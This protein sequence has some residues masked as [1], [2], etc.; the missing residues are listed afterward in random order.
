MFIYHGFQKPSCLFFS[1][2]LFP[3]FHFCIGLF[4]VHLEHPPS[5]LLCC[6]YINHISGFRCR[7]LLSMV[8]FLLY[9]GLSV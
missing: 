2:F 4:C 7:F 9:F 3:F 6:F 8:S 1:P 5:S